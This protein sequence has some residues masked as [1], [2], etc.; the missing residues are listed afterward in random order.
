V[1]LKVTSYLGLHLAS[2]RFARPGETIDT[3][4]EKITDGA[5]ERLVARGF[6]EVEKQEKKAKP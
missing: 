2:G 6:V 3:E 5:V 1:L 4:V